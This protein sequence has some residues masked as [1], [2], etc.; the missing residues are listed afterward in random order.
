M[1]PSSSIVLVSCGVALGASVALS[2]P[3]SS[4]AGPPPV[5][6]AQPLAKRITQWDEYSGRFEAVETV[7]VRPRVSG[8]IEKVHFRDGQIVKPGD[9]L[10]TLEQ[11][12]FQITVE[13]GQAELARTI[14]QADLAENEVERVTPLART[15]AATKRDLDQ[16]TANLA[17][18]QAQKQAAQAGLRAAELNLEWTEIRAPI[19]GR[20]SDRKVD[21]GNLVTGGTA[22]ATILAN[23]VSLDPIHFRFD[24]SEA[25]Y[26]R[27]VR[28]FISGDRQS[29]REA[30][31]PVRIRLADDKDW[32]REGRL[33][34]VDNQLNPRSGTLRARAILDNKDGLFTPGLFARLQLFGGE[35]DALLV[36]DAAI[37]SDQTRKIVFAVDADGVVKAMPV[38][39]GVIVNGLRVVR[40]GLKPDDK[41]V[42]DGLANPFVRPGAKVTPQPGQFK[43][44]VN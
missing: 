18:A 36:P 38:E 29:G 17:V 23:I 27:Y 14:A 32:T 41:I 3:A 24:A 12:Q 30:A 40:T 6:V 2:T 5:T 33:N 15:G 9:L 35:I 20:I 11:R 39:L 34:F 19:G 21:V 31:H 22:G 7:E 10:F 28:Q 13:S 26:M 1:R 42:I 16:R 25:D 43:A 4:Q 8:F 37:V 44:A